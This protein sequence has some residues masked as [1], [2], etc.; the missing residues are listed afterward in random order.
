MN[1]ELNNKLKA[2]NEAET[3]LRDPKEFINFCNTNTILKEY[4]ISTIKG[5]INLKDEYFDFNYFRN[6]YDYI[7][8]MSIPKD[9]IEQ[10]K[11]V[12]RRLSANK[13]EGITMELFEYYKKNLR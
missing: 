1:K 7:K 11:V 9:K 13:V 10:I 12:A 2:I 3:H 5:I 4:S 6:G 8:Q